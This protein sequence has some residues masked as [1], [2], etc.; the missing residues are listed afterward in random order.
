MSKINK[1]GVAGGQLCRGP[2]SLRGGRKKTKARKALKPQGCQKSCL[3][4]SQSAYGK[5][6]K[7]DKSKSDNSQGWEMGHCLSYTELE[8]DVARKESKE[9][10]S[11]ITLGHLRGK[12]ERGG[13]AFGAREFADRSQGPSEK[14]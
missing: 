5:E 12:K 13:M 4:V 6:R 3:G 14:S 1:R 7:K 10:I 2:G 9:K 11:K 8:K